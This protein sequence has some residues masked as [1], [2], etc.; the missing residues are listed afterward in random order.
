MLVFALILNFDIG[1][2]GTADPSP[3]VRSHG[4]TVALALIIVDFSDLLHPFLLAH[5]E[6]LMR[7]ATRD[8]GTSGPDRS[9]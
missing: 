1:C 3:C 4:Y 7:G 9:L 2:G 8:V 5:V 6:G